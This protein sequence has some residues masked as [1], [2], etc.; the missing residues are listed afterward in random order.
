M[1]C[2]KGGGE[3]WFA[4]TGENYL[5]GDLVNCEN[6]PRLPDDWIIEFIRD[7][8]EARASFFRLLGSMLPDEQARLRGLIAGN[9]LTPDEDPKTVEDNFQHSFNTRGIH[10]AGPYGGGLYGG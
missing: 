6:P 4:D 9:T 3:W 2:C 10:T 5:K 8:P 7:I 1:T